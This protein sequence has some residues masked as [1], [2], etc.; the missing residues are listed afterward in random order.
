MSRVDLQQARILDAAQKRMIKFGYRKVTMDELASDLGMSKNTIYKY[1]ASKELIAVA[2]VNRLQD[3][4]NSGL[5]R[6]EKAQSGSLK[7]FS[8]S[9]AFL[10]RQ[11]GLWFAHFFKEVSLELPELWREFMR[12]RNE[13]ILDIRKHVERGIKRGEFRRVN[14]AIALE[15]YLGAIKAVVNPRFLEQEGLSFD[16][17][18]DAVLDI[19]ALGIL[20]K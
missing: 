5:E 3:E 1:F 6:I 15:A 12:F 13:K 19:W 4:I 7:I 9:I 20:K 16:K 14:P 2:L 18:L 11:L 17:A 10:R 8:Y